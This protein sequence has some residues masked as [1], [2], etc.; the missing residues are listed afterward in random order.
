MKISV[1]L[2][3]FNGAGTI[4]SQ[5]K[6]LA[7]QEWEGDWEVIVSNNGSTDDSMMIVE[8]FRDQL[9]DLKIVDAHDPSGP[10]LG[11]WHSYNVGMR[12]AKGEAFVFCESDDEVGV[13]W[14]AAMAKALKHHDFVVARLDYLKLNAALNS[15]SRRPRLQENDVPK[16]D[17]PPYYNFAFGCGFGFKRSLYKKLGELSHQFNYVFDTEYCFRA[18]S[19]GF[20]IHFLQDAVIHYRLRQSPSAIF[21]QQRRWGEEF[22][23]LMCCYGFPRGK[24]AILRRLL[25]VS[26]L[27]LRGSILWP[28]SWL[29]IPSDYEM[30]LLDLSNDLGWALGELKALTKPLPTFTKIKEEDVLRILPES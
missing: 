18:Q 26:S 23:Q 22:K 6:A 27:L 24:L 7:S 29:G 15:S 5:L 3:C 12:A 4:E 9:P 28:L 2:P 10:R 25:S 11:A 8:R 13:G 19:V 16:L 20:E 30:K 1:I 14:L 17:C 21:N